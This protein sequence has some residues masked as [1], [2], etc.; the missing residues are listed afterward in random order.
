MPI[1]GFQ[2]DVSV[3]AKVKIV[4]ELTK[5]SQAT[6]MNRAIDEYC[7]KIISKNKKRI[8]DMLGLN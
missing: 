8:M 5:D 2:L 1:K 6:I 4:S 3:D 7:K